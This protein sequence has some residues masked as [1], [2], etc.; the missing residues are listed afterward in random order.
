VNSVPEGDYA[1]PFERKT[2][3]DAK[4]D[5]GDFLRTMLYQRERLKTCLQAADAWEAMAD[6]FPEL[7]AVAWWLTNAHQGSAEWIKARL[8]QMYQRYV[9]EWD[10]PGLLDTLCDG[11]LPYKSYKVPSN[12]IGQRG[13]RIT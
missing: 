9:A 13:G 12:T 5:D 7:L 10:T 4:A 6:Q 2:S 11:L 1:V 8:V 3:G